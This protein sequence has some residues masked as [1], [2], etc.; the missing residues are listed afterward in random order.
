MIFIYLHALYPLT[1]VLCGTGCR[2]EWK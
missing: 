1:V 2:L